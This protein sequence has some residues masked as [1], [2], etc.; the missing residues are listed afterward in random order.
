MSVNGRLKKSEFAKSCGVN[1]SSIT[2]GI[3][4][5]YIVADPSGLI[6]PTQRDNRDYMREKIAEAR[7]RQLERN[8]EERFKNND[9]SV[10]RKIIKGMPEKPANRNKKSS[11][12]R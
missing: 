4:T 5:G 6:D 8:L 7:E 11:N 9:I 2:R 3:A 12:K 1:P 10:L